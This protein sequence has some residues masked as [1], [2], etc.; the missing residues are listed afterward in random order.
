[1]APSDTPDGWFVTDSAAAAT[2]GPGPCILAPVTAALDPHL[3]VMACALPVGDVNG[4]LEAALQSEP[5]PEWVIAGVLAHDPFLRRRDLLATLKSAGGTALTNWPS[6]CPLSGELAGALEHSGF[7]YQRELEL[8]EEAQKQGFGV[9][10]VVH[11]EAQL[12]EAL[13]LTPA[14]VLVTPGLGTPERE[15][16]RH[17]AQQTLELATRAQRESAAAVRVHYHPG[18][19]D[20]LDEQLPRGIGR[21]RHRPSRQSAG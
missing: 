4:A 19:A 8:L 11:T 7:T 5:P 14:H 17:R 6:V 10:V 9:C 16:R 1:M 21:I 12:D 15:E 2:L 3:A 18:F 13:T 20:M